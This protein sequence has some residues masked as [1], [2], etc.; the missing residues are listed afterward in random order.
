MTFAKKNMKLAIASL[1]VLS[2][3]HTLSFA[4]EP[5][6]WSKIAKMIS[7]NWQSIKVTPREEL[8]DGF[9]IPKMSIV[10]DIRADGTARMQTNIEG[11][12]PA[13][14][15]FCYC[16]GKEVITFYDPKTKES[17]DG[18]L[19]AWRIIDD[20]LEMD[21]LGGAPITVQF[22]KANKNR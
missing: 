2:F 21:I 8:P 6:D 19:Y 5:L 20:S 1:L 16:L 14:S 18:R 11:E 15:E 13:D 4:E 10:L 17:G 9:P 3:T 7:G 12:E 22:K